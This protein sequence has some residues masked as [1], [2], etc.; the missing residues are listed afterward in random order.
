MSQENTVLVIIGQNFKFAH[1]GCDVVEYKAAAEPQEVPEE[2]AK[3]AITEKWA[4]LP[5]KAKGAAKKDG[6]N[7]G[8]G[9]EASGDSTATIQA[10]AD[11]IAA[12]EAR[13]AEA[14]EEA[15]PDLEAELQ[16]KQAELAQLQGE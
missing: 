7:A 16:A 4:K 6:G 15:K 9:A 2:V 1:R 13:M 10:L 3:L 14:A 11:Q 12:L 8:T 5:G